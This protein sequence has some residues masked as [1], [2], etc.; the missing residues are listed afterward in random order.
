[1]RIGGDEVAG[2]TG[3]GSAGGSQPVKDC[4]IMLGFFYMLL[5]RSIWANS[6]R[7]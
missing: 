6:A 3:I 1:M 2:G 5:Q 4:K 7:E